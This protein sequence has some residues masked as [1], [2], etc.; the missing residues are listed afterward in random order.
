MACDIVGTWKLVDWTAAIDD[1]PVTPFG[2]ETTGLITYTEDGRM[3]GTLMRV[4]RP[5]V[6]G[7]T[8]AAAPESERA[9]AAAGYLNYAGTYRLEGSTVVHSVEMSLFPNW[10]GT[11]QVREM[12]WAPNNNGGTDLILAAASTS[13]R[14]ET[15]TN[16]LI[17]RRLEDW[18]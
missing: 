16:R 7:D 13:S 11:D 2:G 12:E 18:V 14:G 4:D 1:K 8:L 10:I 9:A 6:D 15:V 5:P 3:W 17:W